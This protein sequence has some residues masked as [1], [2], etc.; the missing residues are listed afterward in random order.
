MDPT[1]APPGTLRRKVEYVVVALACGVA[2]VS[3]VA[4]V[5]WFGVALGLWDSVGFGPEWGE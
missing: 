3:V 1:P 5:Y 2:I 4:L